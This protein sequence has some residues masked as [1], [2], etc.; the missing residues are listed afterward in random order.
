[1]WNWCILLAQVF[2][3]DILTQISARH[4]FQAACF[5]LL[6]HNKNSKCITKLPGVLEEEEKNDSI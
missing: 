1:M 2:K 4:P 6:N 3:T 5:D